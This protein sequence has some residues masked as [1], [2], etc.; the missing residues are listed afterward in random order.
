MSRFVPSGSNPDNNGHGGGVT[1]TSTVGA[2]LPAPATVTATAAGT[3]V[4]VTWAE[5]D[6]AGE[7]LAQLETAA[8]TG[9]GTA[10]VTGLTATFPN[11]AAGSYT[12]QVRA[13]KD[14]SA[15]LDDQNNGWGTAAAT[16]VTVEAPKVPGATPTDDTPPVISVTVIGTHGNGD[17]YTSDVT[18]NWNVSDPESGVASSTGCT[19]QTVSTDTNG[20]TFTCSATNGV[21][22]SSASSATVKRD[23]TKPTITFTGNGGS[24]TVDQYVSISCAPG[25]NLSGVASSVCDGLQSD[26]YRLIIGTNSL[27]GTDTDNAGN[28]GAGGTSFTVSVTTNS[29]CN[30]TKRWISNAGVAN[31]LCV[32]LTNAAA[33]KARGDLKAH[34]NL[35]GAYANEV[36]AQTGKTIT[37]D[38]A[39]WLLQFATML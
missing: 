22:L 5:V 23:A 31:S 9:A 27:S 30:L 3:T 6:G 32:K 26:A 36:K 20:I 12:V 4:T 38:N 15:N 25:D 13:R 29:L 16:T 19:S 35:L 1:G 34:D 10:K 39:A 14:V 24:Y 17:W 2:K 8:G 28:N 18:V 33:A 37:A 7:Y 21:G 11:V